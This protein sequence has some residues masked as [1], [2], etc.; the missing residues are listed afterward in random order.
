MTFAIRAVVKLEQSS[1]YLQHCLLFVTERITLFEFIQID[2]STLMLLEQT[3]SIVAMIFM[4]GDTSLISAR[5]FDG[6]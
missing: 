4:Y 1:D 3:D 6:L 5:R 2:R